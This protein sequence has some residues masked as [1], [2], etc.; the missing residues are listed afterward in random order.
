MIE[1]LAPGGE[2]LLVEAPRVGVLSAND[3]SPAKRE[4]WIKLNAPGMDALLVNPRLI[5]TGLDL[6]AFSHVVFYETSTS[7]YTVYQSLHRV[8]RLGQSKS[9]FVDFLAYRNTLEERILS[10]MGRK[11]KAAQTL[12][13]KEAA[14]VLVESD[15]DDIQRQLI[16]EALQGKAAAN[17]GE[18]AERLHIFASGDERPVLVSSSPA[19]SLIAFSPRLLVTKLPA[20]ET[21]QLDLFGGVVAASA[22][23][24]RRRRR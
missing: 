12:Y 17:A 15:D 20:G 4:A 19:G 1:S 24:A 22:V 10:R 11:M 21:V 3:M 13:G 23:S 6:L 8:F 14:G 7:L 2:P 18:M 5:E 9:V 16:R